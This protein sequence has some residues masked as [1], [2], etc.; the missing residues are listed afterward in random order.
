VYA[1]TKTGVVASSEALR[2]EM[3][4]QVLVRSVEQAW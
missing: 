1:L 3:P 2:Q 4:G